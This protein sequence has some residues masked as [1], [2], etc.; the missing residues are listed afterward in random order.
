MLLEVTYF[1][2]LERLIEL[3]RC[4]CGCI[5]ICSFQVFVFCLLYF[6][7]VRVF[8]FVFRNSF[9]IFLSFSICICFFIHICLSIWPQVFKTM[10]LFFCLY[11]FACFFHCYFIVTS[12]CLCLSQFASPICSQ[13]N[14]LYIFFDVAQFTEEEKMII[15]ESNLQKK[16]M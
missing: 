6:V 8:V 11:F 3:Q 14:S 4:I 5:C 15:V 16:G 10:Q 13:R 9:C 7:F 12:D 2:Q 1:Q